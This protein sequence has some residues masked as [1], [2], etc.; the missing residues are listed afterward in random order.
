[1]AKITYSTI[2][3]D[4]LVDIKVSGSFHKRLVSLLAALGETLP[5]EEFKKVLERIKTDK[6][7]EDL[8]ELNVHTILMLIYE[9]ETEAKKQSKITTAE[10]DEP[11]STDSSKDSSQDS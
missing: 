2:A 1:M 11:D 3:D 7:P 9:V 5:L 4:T 10:I 8:F 6:P